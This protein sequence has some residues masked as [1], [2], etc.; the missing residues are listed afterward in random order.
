MMT[1]RDRI[2]SI[3]HAIQEGEQTEVKPPTRLGH[4]CGQSVRIFKIF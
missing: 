4:H 3:N 2:N 1:E